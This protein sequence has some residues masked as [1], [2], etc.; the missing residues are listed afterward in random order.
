MPHTTRPPIVDITE[1]IPGLAA[2]ARTAVRLH[3][4]RGN[5]RVG[6][7][8]IGGPMLWPAAEPWPLCHE[9]HGT[10]RNPDKEPMAMAPIAQLHAADV[11]VFPFPDRTDLLQIL[12][13]PNHD[14]DFPDASISV[15][16]RRA[17]DITDVLTDP[18]T[19][20]TAEEEMVP[21]PCVLDPEPVTEYPWHEELPRE[22]RDELRNWETDYPAYQYGLSI[23]SGCK[24]GGGMSWEVTDMGDP[25]TCDECGSVARLVLQLDSSEWD[26]ASD[27]DGGP[28]RWR[29]I[30]DADLEGDAHWEAIEPIGMAIGRYS[31]GGFF[32]C[33]NDHHHPV[34]FYWQ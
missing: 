22:I 10:R 5:P 28:P 33:P 30:E 6:D 20:R 1:D 23:A 25:P 27:H 16:W 18:P 13:C 9:L 14:G 19:P 24:L 7:S 29:P 31:H 8:H 4:R 26:G 15:H 32:G 34:S 3:P 12:W 2:Y 21:F 17:A 11:P